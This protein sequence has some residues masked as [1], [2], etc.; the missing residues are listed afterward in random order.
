MPAGARGAFSFCTVSDMELP[1]DPLA[2]PT[3]IY[4]PACEVIIATQA[5]TPSSIA[6][7]QQICTVLSQGS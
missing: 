4:T 6:F 1:D 2:F 7:T 5:S 3:R